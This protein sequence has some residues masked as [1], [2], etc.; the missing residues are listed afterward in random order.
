[1]LSLSDLTGTGE[2]AA[3]EDCG[4][5]GCLEGMRG[6]ETEV[7]GAVWMSEVVE[8]E[9]GCPGPMRVSYLTEVD[10]NVVLI[11]GVVAEVETVPEPEVEVVR[12]E[13]A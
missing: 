11:D 9:G 8:T 12:G 13:V 6:V 1:M 7:D 3:L 4:R 2:T 10:A 5:D